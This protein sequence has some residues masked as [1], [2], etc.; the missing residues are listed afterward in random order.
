MGNKV[1]KYILSSTILVLALAVI[2]TATAMASSTYRTIDLESP[3]SIEECVSSCRVPGV[4]TYTLYDNNKE[5]EIY[6]HG[7]DLH[8]T[9]WL[10]PTSYSQGK[11]GIGFH[12]PA[13]N[14]NEQVKDRSELNI[15]NHNDPDAL[16]FGK[17]R[18][19]SF[20]MKIQGETQAP[21][22]WT[23]VHQLWQHN[24]TPSNGP[25]FALYVNTSENP[26]DD[27]VLQARVRNDQTGGETHQGIP[28]WE[29][30]VER[31]QFYKFTM[32]YQPYFA[33]YSGGGF[34]EGQMALWFNGSTQPA[35]V[36]NGNF[37][38]SYS[39]TNGISNSFDARVGIYRRMQD[40]N[41]IVFFD[42]IKYGPSASSVGL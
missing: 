22:G 34:Q 8:A 42:D 31:G 20:S 30:K 29:Q 26:D 35:F 25:P 36:Y 6:E 19:L 16:T 33:G 28:V 41:M 17:R 13:A 12:S 5:Y 7:R 18:Y 1:S 11:V 2:P 38:Y 37:G 40:R 14:S 21:R 10:S 23:L 27:I 32:Q 4:H 39:P 15:V 3:S 24:N 9:P